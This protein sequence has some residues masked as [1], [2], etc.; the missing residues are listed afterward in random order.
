MEFIRT[1]KEKVQTKKQE[2]IHQVAEEI[3]TLAVLI[4]ICT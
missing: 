1:I 4:V 3:I 2:E